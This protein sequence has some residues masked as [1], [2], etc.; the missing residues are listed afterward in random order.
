MKYSA[1]AEQ[2]R[3][4]VVSAFHGPAM[5]LGN[6]VLALDVDLITIAASDTADADRRQTGQP[7]PKR[8]EP[9]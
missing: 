8:G 3:L 7:R 6:A 5:T 2:F 9:A 4:K 1:P